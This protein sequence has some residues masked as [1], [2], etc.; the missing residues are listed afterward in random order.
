MSEPVPGT[1]RTVDGFRS[2]LRA[3]EPP[4]LDAGSQSTA[5]GSVTAGQ[6]TPR[7][8]I[9]E[10]QSGDRIGRYV[11]LTRIGHGGMGIIY[12]AQDPDL[13]RRV[14]LKFLLGGDGAGNLGSARLLREAQSLAQLSHP[15]IVAVHDV[16]KRPMSLW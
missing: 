16:G 6:V 9:R 13:D 15:N 3:G 10:L 4:M 14:A 1:G 12:G 5:P 2:T 7:A 11:I 8:P